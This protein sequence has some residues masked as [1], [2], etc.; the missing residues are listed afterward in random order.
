L[1]STYRLLVLAEFHVYKPQLPDDG[2]GDFR[3]KPIQN[4]GDY[5]SQIGPDHGDNADSG[6]ET[7]CGRLDTI[8]HTFFNLGPRAN[9]QALQHQNTADRDAV[10]FAAIKLDYFGLCYAAVDISIHRGING[11]AARRRHDADHGIH[12]VRIGKA[13]E[14]RFTEAMETS[15]VHDYFVELESAHVRPPINAAMLKLADASAFGKILLVGAWKTQPAIGAADSF[16]AIVNSA[17]HPGAASRTRSVINGSILITNAIAVANELD[18][19]LFR[20]GCTAFASIAAYYCAQSRDANQTILDLLERLI[21][22]VSWEEALARAIGELLEGDSI[23]TDPRV[24]EIFRNLQPPLWG[25]QE[26]AV[27]Q[28]LYI[29]DHFGSVLVADPTGSGKTR[30]GVALL[31]CLKNRIA[32]AGGH[33]GADNTLLITPPQVI[34]NWENELLAFGSEFHNI[35]SQGQLS[36]PSEAAA[37]K[38]HRRIELARTIMLDEAHNYLRTASK[39]S[40]RLQFNGADHLMLLTATPINRQVK[41]LFRLIEIMDVDNL[42]DEDLKAYIDLYKRAGPTRQLG[43]KEQTAL[44]KFIGNFLVRRTKRQLNLRVD[45]TPEKHSLPSGR[46][47]RYPQQLPKVYPLNESPEDV[48]IAAKINVLASQLRGLIRLRSLKLRP[49]ELISPDNEEHGLTRRLRAAKVLSIYFLQATLRSSTAALIEHIEGTAAACQYLEKQGLTLP[50]LK[51][52]KNT[53]DMLSKLASFK[54]E[55]PKHN[56]SI[57]LPDWLSDPD[58]YREACEQEIEI[59]RQI[60]GLA[61]LL[62][63]H[64]EWEKARFLHQLLDQH[65]LVLSFDRNLITLH[66]LRKILKSEFPDARPLL[67]TGQ[68]KA[69]Q[70]KARKYFGLGSKE[71]NVIGLCSEVMSEGVNL[72]QAS[73]VV[74]LDVPGVMRIAEQRIGRIDRMNSPHDAIEVYF[75]NDHDEFALRTDRKFFLTAQA[76]EDMIG[77]NINS[78]DELLEKWD[79]LDKWKDQLYSG[80][81]MA[82]DYGEQIEKSAQAFADGIRD[83]LQPVRDLV[84]GPAPLLSPE[85]YSELRH[86]KARVI[87]L[88]RTSAS[89]VRAQ[90]NWAFFCLRGTSSHAST[91]LF[92]DRTPSTDLWPKYRIVRTLPEIAELLRERLHDVS[93]LK[94]E[95]LPLV[96]AEV[97]QLFKELRRHE[98]DSLPNKKLRAIRLLQ[99]IVARELKQGAQGDLTRLAVIRN[100]HQALQPD[101]TDDRVVDYYALAQR[102]LR[103]VQPWLIEE[104][105]RQVRKPVVVGLDSLKPIFRKHPLATEV[106]QRLEE[107]L[108]WVDRVEKRVVAYII[109][110]HTS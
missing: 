69:N 84:S 104:K 47:C 38:L 48:A 8:L 106:F 77:G 22:L 1:L 41:D 49:Y 82:R 11:V 32:L 27:G 3:C 105:K 15:I 53:G 10:R 13:V 52:E 45:E 16:V 64:R 63:L 4:A 44:K 67:V 75:P 57:A 58:R 100:I 87:S 35:I 62:S 60:A 89:V 31:L 21:K 34:E 66:L 12:F 80:R 29:L 19:A 40:E 102:W 88:V 51:E 2:L 18:F 54:T 70:L 33:P 23:R 42:S 25:V 92:L 71:K 56:L 94:P 98:L 73:A 110:V 107:E 93:D 72:Q 79:L 83:A 39:R 108:V 55:L 50:R 78:P 6:T 109:G 36:H 43:K 30:L 24:A 97:D 65:D 103:I 90:N 76:V 91:W 20:S 68:E 96:Q 14:V 99:D 5:Y 37:E 101:N 61:R 95:E 85:Y 86:S 28:A 81:E 74:M 9:A 17:V 59:Y 7:G 46:I 26:E